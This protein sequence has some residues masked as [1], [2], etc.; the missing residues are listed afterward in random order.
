M[1]EELLHGHFALCEVWGLTGRSLEIFLLLQ[2]PLGRPQVL[3]GQTP[4][5]LGLSF[6][7]PGRLLGIPGVPLEVPSVACGPLGI[8]GW[9]CG[10]LGAS[11]GAA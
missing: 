11:L 6:V 4:G 3:P 8:L 10:A 9:P 7:C 1:L 2:G 5:S